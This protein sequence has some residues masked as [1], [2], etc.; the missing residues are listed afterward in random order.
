MPY[1]IAQKIKNTYKKREIKIT[2]ILSIIFIIILGALVYSNSLSV[3]FVWDDYSL[4]ENNPYIR[5]IHSLPDI[6]TKTMGTGAGKQGVYYRP[7]QT[8]SFMIDYHLG[9]LSIEVCHITNNLLHILVALCVYWLAYLV[10]ANKFLSFLTSILFISHPVHVESVTYLSGRSGILTALFMLLCFIF[11]IKYTNAKGKISFVFMVFSYIFALLSKENALILPALLLLYHYAFGKKIKAPAFTA[12]LSIASAYIALRVLILKSA[13]LN[14]SAIGSVLERIPGFFAA[15]LTYIRLLLFPFGLHIN[16]GSKLFHFSDIQV[17]G[18]IFILCFLCILVFKQRKNNQLLFFSMSWFLIAL[19]PV[20]N[21]YPLPFYMAEH[22]LYFPS[23]GFFLI[24]AGGIRQFYNIKRTKLYAALFTLCVV[25]F[26]CSLTIKQNSY[27]NDSIGLYKRSL[28]FTPNNT[29]ML[30]NL[31][32]EYSNANKNGE[33]IKTLHRVIEINPDDARAYNNIGR[34]Y[35]LTGQY[36][37]AIRAI[38]K[39]LIINPNFA[40]AYYNLG[41]IFKR[42]NKPE[43]AIQAFTSAVNNNPNFADAYYSLGTLLRKMGKIEDSIQAFKKAL[44]NN[45]YHAAAHNDLAIIYHSRKQL[46]LAI[47][48]F[49]RVTELGYKVTT[50]FSEPPGLYK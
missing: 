42:I 39:A 33:A 47:K 48:H 9:G 49:K 5:S 21:L 38:R 3:Q 43:E 12:I 36:D 29:D 18:G 6:L 35:V 4:I 15:I 16:Y 1:R 41:L 13:F 11:Y 27:W 22:F 45:P 20:S 34:C 46:D 44:K 17:I 23:L 19:L 8:I 14:T 28:Q 50:D 25:I 10:S 32:N 2:Q 40:G 26:Y 24:I 37:K 31:S 7:L 30:I